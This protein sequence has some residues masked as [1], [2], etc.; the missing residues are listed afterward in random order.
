MK[1][2]L[3]STFKSLSVL[4]YRRYFIGQAVSVIGTWMQKVAQ[5]WLVLE[6]TN[7]GFL[8]GLT[9]AVQQIPSLVLTPLGGV[10]ADRLRRRD[11]LLCTQSAAAIPAVVL[12]VLTLIGHATIG[13]VFVMA[14]VL[15]VV[16]ALDKPARLTFVTEIVGDEHL[17]NAV[18]LNSTVQNTGKVIG[19]AL[20]GVTIATVGLPYSFLAN[21]ASFLAVLSGLWLIRPNYAAA[22]VARPPARGQLMDGI[23]YN[24]QVVLPVYAKSTFHGDA[25]AAGLMFTTMGIGAVVGGLAFAGA[26]R[27][28][29]SRLA[30]MG[31]VF[32]AALLLATIAPTLALAYVTMCLLGAASV[33][34]RTLATSLIQL[35]AKPATRGRVV[36]LLIIATNGTT[37]IG[38]PLIGW[39]CEVW[40]PRVGLGIGGVSTAVA[41]VM[42]YFYM[43]R[44]D[45][46]TIQEEPSAG[47]YESRAAGGPAAQM[48]DSRVSVVVGGQ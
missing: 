33:N 46:I 17:A 27:T 40:N 45:R 5:A 48:N 31:I 22:A 15:G 44:Y 19:P 4:D 32:A 35:R 38:G 23:K 8:L 3:S 29:T 39:V 34:Y 26:M 2:Y 21:A 9:A 16:E 28:S 41:A 18:T 20:A 30:L 25:Q 12:G 24:W 36:S 37:P 6:L 7:S 14:L 11:I 47:R 10:L 1:R 42:A 43:R 13:V